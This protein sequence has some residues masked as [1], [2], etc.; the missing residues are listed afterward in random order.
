MKRITV[1]VPDELFRF[2]KIRAAEAG[3]TMTSIVRELLEDELE[4]L[5]D[6]EEK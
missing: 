5:K 4:R 6:G 1:E 2:W 3:I